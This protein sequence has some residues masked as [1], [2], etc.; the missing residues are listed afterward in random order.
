MS[1]NTA[2]AAELDQVAEDLEALLAY[3]EPFENRPGPEMANSD[4][5]HA[6][7]AAVAQYARERAAWLR[8]Q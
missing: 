1:D 6:G 7:Y 2:R 4:T 5:E 8:G 3:R